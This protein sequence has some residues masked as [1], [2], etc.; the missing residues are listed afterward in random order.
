MSGRSPPPCPFHFTTRTKKCLFLFWIP[1]QLH[2]GAHNISILFPN[3]TDDYDRFRR[4]C[5][6]TR[7][8]CVF[9]QWAIPYPDMQRTFSLDGISEACGNRERMVFSSTWDHERLLVQDSVMAELDRVLEELRNETRHH[10][11]LD[12]L[13]EPT[14]SDL[15]KLG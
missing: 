3:Y 5:V 15:K 13:A 2:A 12:A 4:E 9:R 1:I 8:V 10:A 14:V 11:H 7:S 6:E